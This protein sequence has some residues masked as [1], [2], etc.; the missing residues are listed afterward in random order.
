MSEPAQLARR[1]GAFDAT[2]I[3]MGGIIGS[4]IVLSGA[5]VYG[6]WRRSAQSQRPREATGR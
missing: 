3:V 4:G 5:V 1:F 6:M 2:M